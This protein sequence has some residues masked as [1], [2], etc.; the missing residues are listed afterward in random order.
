M[1]LKI[2]NK[3]H[4]FK[5]PQVLE[6]LIKEQSKTDVIYATVDGRIRELSYTVG[7]DAEIEFHGLDSHDGMRI[8]EATLRYVFAKAA[9][10]INPDIKLRFSYSISRAILAS[11]VEGELTEELY[12]MILKE[13]KHIISSK[14]SIKRLS[15]SKAKATEIY[16]KF[17]YEDKIETLKLREEDIVNLYQAGDYVNY[18]FSYMLPN[19]S[20]LKLYET[21]FYHPGFLIFFPR[22]ELGGKLPEFADQKTFGKALK[23]AY[24]W[25]KIIG[26]DTIANINKQVA[27]RDKEVDFVNLCE[28][29]HNNQ[30]SDLGRMIEQNIEDI[31]LIAVAGPSSSGKTTFTNRLRIELLSKGIKPMMISMDNYYKQKSEAPIDEYGKPDL[32]HVEALDIARFNKDMAQLVMGKSVALPIFDFKLG[33]RVDGPLVKLEE[34]SPILIEGIHALNDRL[35]DLIPS[36][37]KFKI[38][39]APST[40]LHIDNHNPI[41]LTDIRLI[42]RMVRDQKYRNTPATQ[43]IE[44][45]QSVRRGEFRWIYPYQESANF[46]YN[47]ELTYELLVL[48]KYALPHLLSIPRDDK[49]F[50]VANR[51]VKFLKYFKDIDEK[52]VP[53]NSILLE[54]IGGSPFHD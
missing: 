32:E 42:R 7:E 8:Y 29:K 9:H 43:T 10:K 38:F 37:L 36:H 1:K 3:V 35:T 40:Q 27:S 14:I 5:E 45:W 46:V 47:S 30:L 49:H 4:T 28:T 33:K 18:M 15:V 54:F 51:L 11:L 26:G 24:K 48:K 2:E 13:V 23:E 25:G 39:I 22:A 12:E 6:N 21:K 31:K 44:M 53:S 20:Y 34:N 41:S 16:T 19:T 50:I 17:K 52:L